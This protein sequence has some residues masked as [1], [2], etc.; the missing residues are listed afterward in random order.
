LRFGVVDVSQLFGEEFFEVFLH[1]FNLRYEMWFRNAGRIPTHSRPS[2]TDG[3]Q[4]T[5]SGKL[6]MPI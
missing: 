5:A 1:M 4:R 6:P 2:L 3:K